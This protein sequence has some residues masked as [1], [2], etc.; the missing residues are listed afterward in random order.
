VPYLPP[1]LYGETTRLSAKSFIIGKNDELPITGFENSKARILGFEQADLKT[2]RVERPNKA[3][4]APF[5]FADLQNDTSAHNSNNV[6]STEECQLWPYR[7][8]WAIPV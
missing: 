4:A 8:L 3:S 2:G 1:G 6:I 5:T 7:L